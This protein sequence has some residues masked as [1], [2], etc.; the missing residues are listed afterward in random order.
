MSDIVGLVDVKKHQSMQ[1][2]IEKSLNL[3]SYKIPQNIDNIVIKPNLCYY[4]GS[5]TGYTT[6]PELVRS[7]IMLLRNKIGEDID[8]TIAEADASAMRT[9]LAFQVLGYQKM[10]DDLNV[11]LTNL[12]DGPS[13]EV[14]EVINNK[15]INFKV[16]E[17][18]TKSGLLINVPK[19]KIMRSTNITCAMKNL[20]GAISNRRKILYHKKLVETIVAVNKV[21]KPDLNIVDGIIALGK[22]PKRLNLILTSQNAVAT[23]WVAAQIAG[24]NPNKVK[25]LQQSLLE[26]IITNTNFQILGEEIDHYKNLFPKDTAISTNLLWETQ[27]TLLNIYSKIVGDIV[28]PFLEI[29]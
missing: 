23:D 4:W 14:K 25:F 22:H 29:D 18:L 27:F 2:A 24:Y 13:I 1:D 9:R 10:A 5:S 28:P 12:S 15:E 21:I 19:L 17:I 6:D 3:I 16:P 7:L 20:F 8:I 26:K 11:N